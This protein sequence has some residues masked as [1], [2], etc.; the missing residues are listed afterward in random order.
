[1][2][3]RVSYKSTIYA[4]YLGNFVQSIVINLTPILFV[5]I[6]VIYD[7]NIASLGVL[8][9]VNFITQVLADV[10]LSKSVDK[11]G[12]RKFVVIAPIIALMG[13]VIFLLS[14]QIFPKD[15]MKGFLIGTIVF[16]CSG[17]MLELLLSPIINAIPSDE[18]IQAMNVLHSFY[19]WGQL[20]VIIVTTLLLKLF[21][22]SY[23]QWIVLFWCIFPIVSSILF[24]KV[25]LVE[26]IGE[27]HQ[28]PN[29]D[30]AKSKYFILGFILILCGGA[31]EQI[32]AQWTSSFF[33]IG[34][35]FSKTTGDLI[36]VGFFA[37]VFASSRFLYGKYGGKINIIK[38]M[39]FGTILTAISFIIFAVSPYPFFTVMASGLC[40]I[41][42]SLLWPGTVALC[43]E[44]FPM[45]GTW[46]FAMLA[47]SGD[48]GCSMGPWI[49]GIIADNIKS[50][51]GINSI[52]TKLTIEQIG[53]RAGMMAGII[54]PIAAFFTLRQMR[55]FKI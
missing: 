2:E 23:W 50:V 44:Y 46:M 20:C 19:A 38:A 24:F 6:M 49:T 11:Y 45:A 5:P 42:V 48:I 51:N 29:R 31:S 36:G 25:P 33:E 16:S 3:S 4:C 22:T 13:F 1:M 8:A 27:E 43:A 47:F 9:A 40:G 41:G 32:A 21:G 15:P 34:L 14:P 10:L 53:L 12:F 39:S 17:G 52:F 7:L 18:K 28:M 54:F 37:F 55:K 26:V 35:N 30:I